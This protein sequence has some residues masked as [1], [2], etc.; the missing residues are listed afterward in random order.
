M[1][2]SSPTG[3]VIAESDVKEHA[4]WGDHTVSW[5]TP[6]GDGYTVTAPPATCVQTTRQVEVNLE[7]LDEATP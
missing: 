3:E 2:C 6:E 5:K 1:K 7:K 4:Q